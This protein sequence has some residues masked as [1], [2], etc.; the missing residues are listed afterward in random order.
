M[1]VITGIAKGHKLK[2]PK[3]TNTRPTT[4]RVK[5]TLFN[6]IGDIHPDSI[7]LDL[8]AGS[9]SIGIEFLSRGAKKSY[10]IDSDIS[11]YKTILENIN[12][13][14]FNDRSEVYKNTYDKALRVLRNKGIRFNYIFLD[15]PYDKG[16]VEKSIEFIIEYDLLTKDG[17]IIVEHEKALD[18]TAFSNKYSINTRNYG[19]TSVSFLK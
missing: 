8:F 1:R 10:F 14:K 9:G 7:I 12:K 5:E 13:T 17:L 19:D 6:I 4:D 2:A 18:L 11:S 15:P 16:L 3:G